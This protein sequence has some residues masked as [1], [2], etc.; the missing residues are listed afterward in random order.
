[1]AW[2]LFALIA[3]MGLLWGAASLFAVAC[4]KASLL[5]RFFST[6]GI[7]LCVLAFTLISTVTA[8]YW[9]FDRMVS[10]PAL[11]DQAV[12]LAMDRQLWFKILIAFGAMQVLFVADSLFQKKG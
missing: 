5:V 9:G 8:R 4:S 7:S 2:E 12:F 3:W 11:L 10:F 1:M 6:L